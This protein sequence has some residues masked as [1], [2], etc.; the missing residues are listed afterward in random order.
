MMLVVALILI[1]ASIATPKKAVGS[2]PSVFSERTDM[3]GLR[4]SAFGK[5]AE[6]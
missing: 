4:P 1:V 6:G 2:Q 3:R 5:T